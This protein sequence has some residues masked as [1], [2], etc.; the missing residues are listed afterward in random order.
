ME[1]GKKDAFYDAMR[2]VQFLY[3]PKHNLIITWE[4]DNAEGQYFFDNLHI[5]TLVAI[6]ERVTAYASAHSISLSFKIESSK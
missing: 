5:Q 3:G 1:P 6:V 2:S 4:I